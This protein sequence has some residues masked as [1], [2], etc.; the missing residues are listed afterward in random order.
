MKAARWHDR[1]DVRVEEVQEPEPGPNSVQ[2]EPRLCGICGS[3]LHEYEDGPIV[4][5]TEDEHPLTGERAPVVLGHEYSGVVTDTGPEVEGWTS[6][7]RVVVEPLLYCGECPPCRQ[8]LYNLCKITGYHGLHGSGGGFSERTAV[9]E[10]MVHPI[11]DNVSDREAALVE[12]LS[13]AYQ[14]VRRANLTLGDDVIVFGAGPIGQFILQVLRMTGTSTVVSVELLEGRREL[15]EALGA[16]IVL[17]PD[18]ENVVQVVRQ[19]T[20]EFGVDVAFDAAGSPES[21]RTAMR[22]TRKRGTLVNVA[23][24]KDPVNFDFNELLTTEQTLT[25]SLGYQHV[26]PEVL[27]LL[28]RDEI[29][30]EPVISDVIDLNDIVGEGFERMIEN[31]DDVLKILVRP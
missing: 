28:A 13:V 15:A 19:E 31:R 26:F 18:Q 14:A 25:A 12:P 17:N 7:D 16:D 11:P 24:W 23:Q 5:P 10:Y 22:A 9:P 4:I 29:E 27:D 2:I 21:L 8:G 3:D 30:S 1:K 6:G 20:D